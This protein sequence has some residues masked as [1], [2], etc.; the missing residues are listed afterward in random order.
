MLV[1]KK[2]S[3]MRLSCGKKVVGVWFR[4]VDYINNPATRSDAARIMAANQIRRLVI[5]VVMLLGYAYVYGAVGHGIH[6]YL[7][8]AA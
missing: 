2:P 6:H 7:Q 5:L 1:S 3:S 8:R 4:V